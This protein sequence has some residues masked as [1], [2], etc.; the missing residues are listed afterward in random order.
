MRLC[1]EAVTFVP[2]PEEQ[3]EQMTDTDNTITSPN[4]F[5][6]ARTLHLW[7]VKHQ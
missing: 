5:H 2:F 6:E 1:Q 3:L 4:D 7:S